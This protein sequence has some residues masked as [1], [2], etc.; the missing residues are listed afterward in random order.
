[1]VL[2]MSVGTWHSRQTAVAREDGAYE[3]TFTSPAAGVYYI[4]V[5]CASLGLAIVNGQYLLL[6]VKGPSGRTA[7]E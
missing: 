3:V 2:A 4:Y 7:G 1:M 6:T 5:Q